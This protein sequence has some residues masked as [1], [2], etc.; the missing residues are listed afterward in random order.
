MRKA[1]YLVLLTILLVT[2]SSCGGENKGDNNTK[3]NETEQ[4]KENTKSKII[5]N[6]RKK[7]TMMNFH[8]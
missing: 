5:K 7:K 2:F 6:Q 1:I 3:I 4:R 8:T